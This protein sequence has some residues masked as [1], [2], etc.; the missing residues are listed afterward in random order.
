MSNTR[1][2]YWVQ[3]VTNNVAFPLSIAI[4]V[5]IWIIVVT[6]LGTIGGFLG[7]LLGIVGVI[8][9][10]CFVFWST[11]HAGE[12]LHRWSYRKDIR[13][14]HSRATDTMSA[15]QAGRPTRQFFVYLRSFKME[16]AQ[17]LWYSTAT[18]VA[19]DW[20]STTVDDELT[21]AFECANADLIC[22][23]DDGT[24][25][26]GAARIR[27]SDADWRQTAHALMKQSAG[28]IIVP[29]TTPS[30]LE[31][32]KLISNDATLRSKTALLMLPS[33][34]HLF[35]EVLWD[36]MLEKAGAVAGTFPK[37]QKSGMIFSFDGYA[38]PLHG[39]VSGPIDF[40]RKILDVMRG[41]I[42]S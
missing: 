8:S 21:H 10:I 4:V 12:L 37:F 38:V 36:V 15:I 40:A 2:K 26:V 34:V 16:T 28:I 18:H 29:A 33:D 19:D 27:T 30:V 24:S 7:G 11:H 22:L 3:F 20:E 5:L 41:Q 14:R 6:M 31:E 42:P 39:N 9:S 23:G 17:C 13:A 25:K 35:S 1:R 32:L